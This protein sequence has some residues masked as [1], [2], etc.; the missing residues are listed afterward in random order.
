MNYSILSIWF[1]TALLFG[2]CSTASNPANNLNKIVIINT[3][4]SEDISLFYLEETLSIG[5]E[6]NPKVFQ[7][8]GLAV[9]NEGQ[10][11]I[12]DDGRIKVFSES[13]EFL[14]FISRSGDGPKEV[15]KPSIWKIIDDTIFVQPCSWSGPRRVQKFLLDGRWIGYEQQPLEYNVDYLPD[16]QVFPSFSR[17]CGQDRW[18][19]EYFVDRREGDFIYRTARYGI[20]DCRRHKTIQLDLEPLEW[21]DRFVYS[22]KPGSTT[23]GSIPFTGGSPRLAVHG[24]TLAVLSKDGDELM[25]YDGNIKRFLTVRFNF[26]GDP[27]TSKDRERLRNRIL[28]NCNPRAYEFYR[29]VPFAKRRNLFS[30]V[31]WYDDGLLWL[32][33]DKSWDIDEEKGN[34]Y[35]ILNKS[36]QVLGQQLLPFYPSLISGNCIYGVVPNE[37]GEPV[38]KRFN[39]IRND[40]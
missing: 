3:L 30:S 20:F 40:Y 12:S 37:E 33:R 23:R 31:H 11:Y 34:Q 5:G 38:V 19:F 36:G 10:I 26:S 32:S 18:F 17:Y 25:L 2:G 21:R 22:S 14:R 8:S 35:I 16:G 4:P 7:P 29:R 6:E 9:D 15:R 13:G 28:K 27:V 1:L 39:L 24:D